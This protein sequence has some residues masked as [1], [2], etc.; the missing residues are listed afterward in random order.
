VTSAEEAVEADVAD[1]AAEENAAENAG[2]FN[3]RRKRKKTL[4]FKK[5][6]SFF[7]SLTVKSK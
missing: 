3:V 6:G 1:S 4:S 7:I 2:K 5:I